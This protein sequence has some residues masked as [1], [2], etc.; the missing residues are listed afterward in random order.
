MKVITLTGPSNSGKTTTLNRLYERLLKSGAT[1]I[2]PPNVCID[3]PST[4]KE[5]YINWKGKKVGIVTMGDWS[6]VII[7]YLGLYS[8]RTADVL[9][10]ADNRSTTPFFIMDRHGIE[11]ATIEKRDIFEKEL[12]DDIIDKLNEFCNE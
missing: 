9:I 11:Y 3:S 1:D 12:V 2:L 8:G 5:Y 6:N 7:W 4:D 10:I